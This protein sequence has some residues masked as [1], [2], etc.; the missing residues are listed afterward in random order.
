MAIDSSE[1]FAKLG[2]GTILQQVPDGEKKKVGSTAKSSRQLFLDSISEQIA[3]AEEQAK[4]YTKTVPKTNIPADKNGNPL[5]A[6]ENPKARSTWTK[7]VNGVFTLSLYFGAHQFAEPRAVQGG[8]KAVVDAL[9]KIKEHAETG[10]LDAEFDALRDASKAK[11]LDTRA[12]K[13][14]A[15]AAAPPAPPAAA[16]ATEAA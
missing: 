4:I 1:L 13:A 11:R 16:E 5:P 6:P 10:A 2:L 9:K 7:M 14:A 8:F 12:K 3:K 15:A